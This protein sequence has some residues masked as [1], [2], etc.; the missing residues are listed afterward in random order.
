MK[1]CLRLLL[2]TILISN[3]SFTYAQKVKGI[4]PTP[5]MGWNSWNAYKKKNVNE[6]TIYKTIDLMVSDG[7]KAAGYNY[8]IID[9]GWRGHKLDSKGRI[10]VDSIKFPHGIKAMADYAHSKGL[11]FGLHVTPGTQDC[12]G[13]E[14]GMYGHEE[15]NLKQFESW[16]LDMLK[17]DRCQMNG[18]SDNWDEEATREVYLKWSKLLAHA[19]RPILFSISAYVYRPWY[20]QYCNMARTTGDLWGFSRSHFDGDQHSIMK[21]ADLNNECADFAGN[22]YWND[23]DML[24]VGNPA[25]TFDEQK[26]QFA[27]WCIMTSP[28]MMGNDLSET[29]T[30][31]HDLLTNKMAIRVNQD[32]T[33]QGRRI[34]RR[35]VVGA[36]NEI[37]LKHLNN[38]D[39]AVVFLNRS[40][41]AKSQNLYFDDLKLSN[42]VKVYDI[43][44]KKDM[45]TMSEKIAVSLDKHACRFFLLHDN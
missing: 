36:G 33:E 41:E 44:D 42:H 40:D 34:F 8:V 20:P 15:A 39:V 26:T 6:Q 1:R 13:D 23:P 12:G 31:V 19:S 16:G 45:S 27:L 38:G 28:L 14:V 9:G 5:P 29:S 22:G 32:T 17:I 18:A 11:K 24:V 10:T 4:T 43:F 7:Y 35:S 3:M 37:W 25:L 2:I 30:E 21:I